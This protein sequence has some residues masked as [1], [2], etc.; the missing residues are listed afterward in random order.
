MSVAESGVG[1]AAPSAAPSSAR[2]ADGAP[3]PRSTLRSVAV[4]TEH[5]GWSLT[6]EPVV[7]GL[8]V[9]WSWAGVV[10]GLA[11]V[12]AF[13]A[14]T[15]LKLVL[16][17]RW[18]HRRLA[19]TKVA[20]RLAVAELAVIGVLGVL[21]LRAAQQAF[22]A[23]LVAAV[24]LVALELWYD[25]RSRSRRLL[26]ELAGTVGISAVVAAIALAGGADM[27]LAIGLWT[28]VAA[29]AAAAVPCV[30]YQVLELHGR[31]PRRWSSDLAQV[32]AVV[33]V[34]TAVVAGALPVLPLLAV[35]AA[36]A[37]NLR[38]VRT[39]PPRPVIIGIR[40]MLMGL[41]VG[42]VTV[43]AVLG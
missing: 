5:G 13:M 39:T 34:A 42:V 9:A 24:P 2:S 23:P 20:A 32:L 1:T 3:T 8:A 22:W 16:V 37:W 29:R 33:A 6:L 38:S 7:L 43:V 18:R 36:A 10:L 28:V 25:M 17:D 40:Q 27:G 4:P 21:A 12:L 14:R 15:P 19:R 26:P 11:A 41:A 31:A 35:A 30:R